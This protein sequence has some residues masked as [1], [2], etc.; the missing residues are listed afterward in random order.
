MLGFSMFTCCIF[1]FIF[2]VGGLLSPW[3]LLFCHVEETFVPRVCYFLTEDLVLFS[4]VLS[5]PHV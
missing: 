5:P 2:V 4:I 1:V 3:F